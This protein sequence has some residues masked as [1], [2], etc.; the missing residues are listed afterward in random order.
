MN[1]ELNI[2]RR[3]E[4]VAWVHEIVV[5]SLSRDRTLEIAGEYTR[6]FSRGQPC[7]F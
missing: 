6:T 7:L 4:S 3:L 5:D 2:R 1:E